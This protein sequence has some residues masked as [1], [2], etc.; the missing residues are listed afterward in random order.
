MRPQFIERRPG[1]HRCQKSFRQPEHERRFGI[2]L[3]DV[4][5]RIFLPKPAVTRRTGCEVERGEDTHKLH[6][7]ALNGAPMYVVERVQVRQLV[8]NLLDGDPARLPRYQLQHDP[9]PE[10]GVLGLV[11]VGLPGFR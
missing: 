3:G 10:D 5:D 7:I 8:P 6:Q 2:E 11:A 1:K 9:L 4:K